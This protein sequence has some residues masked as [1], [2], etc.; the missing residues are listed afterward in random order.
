VGRIRNIEYIHFKESHLI[1][2]KG[3]YDESS[4]E[5][6][7][8]KIT[9]E[10]ERKWKGTHRKYITVYEDGNSCRIFLQLM[11]SILYLLLKQKY[12]TAGIAHQ[13]SMV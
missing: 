1:Y 12:L 7:I 5:I 8:R 6:S 9:F 3:G 11:I 4:E 13:I 10:V 2:S